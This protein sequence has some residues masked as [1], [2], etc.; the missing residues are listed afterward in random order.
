MEKPPRVLSKYFLRTEAEKFLK[1]SPLM[2]I[3]DVK[4]K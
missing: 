2:L 3:V 4:L 1:I